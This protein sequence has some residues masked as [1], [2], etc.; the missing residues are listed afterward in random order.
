MVATGVL[1]IDAC[2]DGSCT[3]IDFNE[4]RVFQMY[5]DGKT[6]QL[7]LSVH[8][9]T[10]GTAPAWDDAGWTEVTGIEDIGEG[11]VLDEDELVVGDPTALLTG[12]QTT[13]YVRVE[14]WNDGSLGD[15]SFT[16]LRA[17]KLF[18]Y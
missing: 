10:S 17:L 16:E 12:N 8:S 14:T 15:S 4:A 2:S 7:R 13:R 18:G 5:S 1:V 11:T 6:T 9:E 3:T